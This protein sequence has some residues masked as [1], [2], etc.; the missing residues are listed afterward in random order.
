[1]I[2]VTGL[3]FFFY[4]QRMVLVAFFKMFKLFTVSKGDGKLWNLKSG[5]GLQGRL[6]SSWRKAGSEIQVLLVSV[7]TADVGS[8]ALAT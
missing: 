3:I 4:Q 6:T 8:S 5:V 2:V 7:V 1:M